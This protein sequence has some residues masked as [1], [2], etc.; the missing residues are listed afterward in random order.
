MT[1]SKKASKG[2]QRRPAAAAGGV[3]SRVSAYL[4]VAA[5]GD[6]QAVVRGEV[7]VG[8]PASMERVHAVFSVTRADPQQSALHDAPQL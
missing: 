2:L 7:Q 5:S 8:H 6:Q 1:D 3:R 4:D